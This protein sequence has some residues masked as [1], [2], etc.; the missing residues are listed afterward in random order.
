MSSVRISWVVVLM[1]EYRELDGYDGYD[2]I[3]LDDLTGLI[4]IVCGLLDGLCIDVGSGNWNGIAMVGYLM[5]F[6][7]V[8]R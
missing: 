7:A 6:I 3:E 2:L 4:W 5:Q 1:L 8:G